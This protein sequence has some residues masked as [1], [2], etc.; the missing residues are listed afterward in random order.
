MRAGLL[1]RASKHVKSGYQ[2]LSGNAIAAPLS[3]AAVTTAAT[4]AIASYGASTFANTQSSAGT[5]VTDYT[6]PIS[7]GYGMVKDAAS[8]GMM[9]LALPEGQEVERT[10]GSYA[11]M[12]LSAGAAGATVAHQAMT[13]SASKAIHKQFSGKNAFNAPSSGKGGF[14]SGLKRNAAK[15]GN[16]GY[17]AMG[18][19]GYGASATFAAA[20]V[21][22]LADRAVTRV[23]K[24][25][26]RA[27]TPGTRLSKD[28]VLNTSRARTKRSS[29]TGP[30][31]ADHGGR[32]RNVMTG[33]TVL[34]LH[35][36]GGSGGVLR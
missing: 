3:Q 31:V 17:R 1:K 10:S 14:M 13:D 24:S 9:N 35:K 25:V 19:M 34:A 26:M 2:G 5:P 23:A 12:G 32:M 36:T 11:M 15:A 8:R 30:T 21:A 27:G 28:N 22:N 4:G 7:L 6:N 18:M 16:V 20:A 29:P 33:S